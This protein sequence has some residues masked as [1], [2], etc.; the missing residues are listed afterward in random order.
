[1]R[2]KK[3]RN[4][5]IFDLRKQGK[6]IRDIAKDLMISKTTVHNV[7]KNERPSRKI[8]ELPLTKTPLNE[9]YGFIFENKPPESNIEKL[10]FPEL[11]NEFVDFYKPNQLVEKKGKQ[12]L[13]T[14]REFIDD[15]KE[16]RQEVSYQ[17]RDISIYEQMG[18]LTSFLERLKK[19]SIS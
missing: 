14:V 8:S 5:R 13:I 7:L 12:I 1:M 6:S 11:L 10:P 19:D 15:N 4:N 9:D 16:E 2:T 3:E 17:S 18:L